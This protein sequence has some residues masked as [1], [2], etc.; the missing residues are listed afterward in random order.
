MRF[1]YRSLSWLTLF[2]SVCIHTSADTLILRDHIGQLIGSVVHQSTGAVIM[3]VSGVLLSVRR[4]DIVEMIPSGEQPLHFGNNTLNS[5]TVSNNQVNPNQSYNTYNN[6]TTVDSTTLPNESV[7]SIG[8]IPSQPITETPGAIAE[9]PIE[10]QPFIGLPQNFSSVT[11]QPS[12]L[13]PSLETPAN[14]PMLP[15]LLPKGKA[16]KVSGIGVRFRE[17]PSLDYPIVSTLRGSSVLLEIE[18][19]DGWL[20]AKTLTGEQGW[21]HLNFVQPMQNQLMIVTGDN[22]QVRAGAGEIHRSLTRLRRNDIVIKL[23]E[24][25]GWNFILTNDSIAGWSSA[26]FLQPLENSS[27]LTTPMRLVQN[28]AVGMPIILTRE[29]DGT[30]GQKLTFTVRDDNI[31]VSGKTKLCILRAAQTTDA[32]P[33][34]NLS[35]ESILARQTLASS[36]ELLNAGFP[37]ELAVTY[38]TMDIVTMLG[39]READGWKYTISTET[40]EPMAFALILQEGPNRGIVVLIPQE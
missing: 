22:L 30:G 3:D 26:E 17:G 18:V 35:S 7:N 11:E 13:T 29:P 31:V 25:P 20:H 10:S 9:T 36:T 37:E 4:S 6:Q 32:L 21:I 23:N 16:Y 28:D 40:T 27:Q 33:E 1:Y 14:Q 38:T 34:L 12:D 24:S 19:S 39:M 8:A 2:F 5:N 15:V